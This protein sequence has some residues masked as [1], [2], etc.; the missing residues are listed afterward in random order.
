MTDFIVHTA[1]T[2]PVPA[3]EKLAQIGKA[4]GFV[5]NL[6]GILAESPETLEGYDALFGLV[7]KT[8]LTAIEQQV[9]FL[10]VNYENEC[11]YCMA[12]HTAL[13]GMAKVPAQAVSALREGQTIADARL[14]ALRNF[15]AAVTRQRGDVGEAVVAEFLAAGFTK[16]NV[17]EIVLIVATKTISNYTNHIARTPN[18]A[19]M[20]NTAWTAPSRRAA[21]AA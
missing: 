15:A 1:Q 10:A 6:H 16:R 14:E 13:A 2:A 20:A 4:W 3:A 11:A 19:F 21:E 8:T 7:G 5:P 18:D 12:G 9:A 17:L